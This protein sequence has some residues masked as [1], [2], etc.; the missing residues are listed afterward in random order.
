MINASREYGD[1]IFTSGGTEANN[2]VVQSCVQHYY[3]NTSNAQKPHVITSNIEHDSIKLPLNYLASINQIEVTF[4]EV[5]KVYGS[6]DPLSVIHAIRPNTCLISIMMANNETGLIQPISQIGNQLK[7]VNSLRKKE[8][9]NQIYFHTDA[10]QTIGKLK[11]DVLDLFIDYVTI[12][13]HKF[14]GPRI[15]ALFRRRDVPLLPMFYG[16]GQENKYRPG[17]ENTPM[18]AALGKACNLVTVGQEEFELKFLEL[19]SLLEKELISNFGDEIVINCKENKYGKLP[20]TLSIAFNNP[21]LKGTSILE[22]TSRIIASVGSACHSTNHDLSSVLINSGV[23]TS[24]ASTT[25][26]LSV[27]RE[28]KSQDIYDAVQDLNDAVNKLLNN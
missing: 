13:G 12:V 18:I 5:S 11:V 25:I 8:E 20:N 6:I 9:L 7:S 16:G 19:V 26:R 17:T 15:G 22:S 2:W 21:N 28:T 4:V 27:G 14:Y 3:Q 23:S 1:I 10:A 24:L